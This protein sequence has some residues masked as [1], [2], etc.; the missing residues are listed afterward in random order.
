MGDLTAQATANAVVVDVCH[1]I[2]AQGILAG[3]DRQRGAA[4]EADA[5]MI[6]S[7]YLG[8][9]PETR[10]HDALA[11]THEPRQLRS[12]PPLTRE[13]ALAIGNDDLKT[14][15]PGAHGLAQRL[16]HRRDAIGVN[17]LD[18]GDTHALERGLDVEALAATIC[19]AAAR[20]DVLL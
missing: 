14:L 9:D 3:L 18:P 2:A 17:P 20:Q 5:G 6:A 16:K 4:R 7:A 10:A 13:L 15:L 12:Q 11:R 8:I 19:G 1:G